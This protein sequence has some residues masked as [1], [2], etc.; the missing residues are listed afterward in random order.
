MSTSRA[1]DR[2]AK[3]LMVSRGLRRTHALR[4]ARQARDLARERGLSYLDAVAVI[5]PAHPARSESDDDA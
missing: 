5:L 1:L 4:V 3:A 2:D